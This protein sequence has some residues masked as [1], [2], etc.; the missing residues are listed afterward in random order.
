MRDVY[1]KGRFGLPLQIIIRSIMYFKKLMLSLVSTIHTNNKYMPLALAKLLDFLLRIFKLVYHAHFTLNLVGVKMPYIKVAFKQSLRNEFNE[2]KFLTLPCLIMR[3]NYFT[4]IFQ[5]EHFKKIC[6]GE[7]HKFTYKLTQQPNST[8][9]FYH[10]LVKIFNMIWIIFI[11]QTRE[12]L[13]LMIFKHL[14]KTHE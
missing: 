14:H 4:F 9:I 2:C 7:S 1:N 13:K 5:S 8:D 12:C 3:I 11:A 10:I 6:I